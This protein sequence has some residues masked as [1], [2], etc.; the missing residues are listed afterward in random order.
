MIASSISLISP[1]AEVRT[2]LGRDNL[3]KIGEMQA[4]IPPAEKSTSP[5]R[6]HTQC[7]R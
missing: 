2:L 3:W 1:V 7:A 5:S 4:D 6:A